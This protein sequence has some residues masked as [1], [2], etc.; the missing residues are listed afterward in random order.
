MEF[1]LTPGA[2]TGNGTY[3]FGLKS[4][5]TTSA[6]FSAKEGADAPQLLIT[7]GS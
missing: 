4:D 7:V 6:I 3:S 5:G 2:V 1:D